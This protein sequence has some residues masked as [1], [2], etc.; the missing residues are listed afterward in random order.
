MKMGYMVKNE[1]SQKVITALLIVNVFLAIDLVRVLK[2]HFNIANSSLVLFLYFTLFYM[3][4]ILTELIV[5]IHNGLIDLMGS[6]KQNDV[7]KIDIKEITRKQNYFHKQLWLIPTVTMFILWLAIGVF[8][9]KID[10]DNLFSDWINS[11]VAIGTI[12]L[13]IFAWMAYK[14]YWKQ[15]KEATI[16]DRIIRST[17]LMHT[18]ILQFQ[19]F[20]DNYSFN[21]TILHLNGAK[22]TSI[23]VAWLND[24]IHDTNTCLS[25]IKDFRGV[26]SEW[27]AELD[28]IHLFSES[29]KKELITNAPC[30]NRL[31]QSS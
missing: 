16:Y 24:L 9:L 23:P 13:A 20:I 7:T 30:N 10:D 31:F 26:I 22:Q 21:T 3:P 18:R 14:G 4:L 2:Q 25:E 6:G 5:V 29:I 1:D 15:K 28:Y 12:A 8:L 17:S 27:K 11:A 19:R